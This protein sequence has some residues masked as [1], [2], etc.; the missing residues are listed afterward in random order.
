M[1]WIGWVATAIFSGSYMFRHP[2][3]LRRT[4]AASAFLLDCL[5]FGHWCAAGGGCECHRG[6]SVCIFFAPDF[7]FKE[8]SR[9][10]ELQPGFPFGIGGLNAPGMRCPQEMM[11]RVN[12]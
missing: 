12:Q 8:R 10:L 1:N 6:G 3:A 5:R 11:N 2:V 7:T 9:G 4:Q